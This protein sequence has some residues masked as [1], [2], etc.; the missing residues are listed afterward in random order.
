MPEPETKA[1][2][3]LHRAVQDWEYLSDEEKHGTVVEALDQLTE[4]GEERMESPATGN[5]YI[6]TRWVDL[7][8]GKIRALSKREDPEAEHNVE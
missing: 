7:G 6:V 3:M 1:A 5:R 4:T 2:E 8:G